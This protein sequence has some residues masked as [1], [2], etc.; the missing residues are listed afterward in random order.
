MDSLPTPNMSQR[1]NLSELVKNSNAIDQT[2]LIRNL[3]HSEILLN[4][5]NQMLIVLEKYARP[6]TQKDLENARMECALVSNWLF[7]YYT[8]IFNRILKGELDMTMFHK[9]IGILQQIEEGELDQYNASI[10]VGTILKEIYIDSAMK[11]ADKLD[12]SQTQSESSESNELK[13]EKEQKKMTWKEYKTHK[14]I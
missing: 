4:E 11:K 7:T 8:D 2:D 1:L 6:F 12:Q 14:H 9:F 10:Q 3:K 13:K 5:S